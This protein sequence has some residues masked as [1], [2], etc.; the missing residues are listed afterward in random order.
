MQGIR[1]PDRVSLAWEGKR[2]TLDI[3][4]VLSC[5][6]NPVVASHA[7]PGWGGGGLEFIRNSTGGMAGKNRYKD[8][9]RADRLGDIHTHTHTY[10]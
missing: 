6:G 2:M 7:S 4:A 1:H 3:T 9:W 5:P 10:R 8:G